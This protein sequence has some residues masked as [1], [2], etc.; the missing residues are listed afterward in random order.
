MTSINYF[1]F[2]LDLRGLYY[3]INYII[4]LVKIKST[5]QKCMSKSEV[6]CASLM[7]NVLEENIDINEILEK[8]RS[9]EQFVSL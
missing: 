9:F 3:L 5:M 8:I 7:N 6:R 1:F 2:F 4:I